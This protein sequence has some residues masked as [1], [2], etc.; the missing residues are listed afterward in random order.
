MTFSKNQLLADF[1]L[2]LL[3]I[4]ADNIFRCLNQRLYAEVRDTL[5]AQLQEESEIVQKIFERMAA[6]D[7]KF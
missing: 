1:Y 2:K 6:E 4:P 5:A 3:S 7:T